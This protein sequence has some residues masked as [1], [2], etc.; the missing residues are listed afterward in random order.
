MLIAGVISVAV[1]VAAWTGFAPRSGVAYPSLVRATPLKG[2]A[3]NFVLKDQR[4]RSI[5]LASQRGHEVILAFFYSHCPSTCPLTA[6]KLRSVLSRFGRERGRIRVLIVSTDPSGDT[7]A[8]ASL[9]L[10]RNGSASWHFLMGSSTELSRVWRAYYIFVRP[11][12]AGSNGPQHQ[13][14]LYF[15]GPDGKKQA[16]MEDGTPGPDIAQDLH[17]L[18]KDKQWVSSLPVSPTVGARAP[19]FDLASLNGGRIKLATMLR[20]PL[21]INFWATWC[22]PCVREMPLLARTY[23]RYRGRINMIGIDEQEPASQVRS[24]V[25]SVHASYPIALDSTGDVE[26]AYQIS[27]IP[28]T[29]FIGRSG[30]IQAIH[31]GALT[32]R[33]LPVMVKALLRQ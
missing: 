1:A 24:F 8:S 26:Y 29:F 17:I 18:L 21:I 13:A 2:A 22:P 6:Q 9:F 12:S 28:S 20:R 11:R 10:R 27:S 15:I 19:A 14:Y 3:P 23:N 16:L 4:G 33:R 7:P 30:I 5:S 25:R 32:P 31:H